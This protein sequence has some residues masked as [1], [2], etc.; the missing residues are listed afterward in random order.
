MKLILKSTQNKAILTDFIEKRSRTVPNNIKKSSFIPYPNVI[1]SDNCH[2]GNLVSS[3]NFSQRG[4]IKNGRLSE[5]KPNLKEISRNKFNN[6]QNFEL[7]NLFS[8]KSDNNHNKENITN[9]I[10]RKGRDLHYPIID[11]KIDLLKEYN[12][13][14]INNFNTKYKLVYKT[15]KPKVK[16]DIINIFSSLKETKSK[17]NKITDK[18][19]QTQNKKYKIITLFNPKSLDEKLWAKKITQH[20]PQEK[21]ISIYTLNFL[22]SK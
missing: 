5:F 11:N 13:Q 7:F 6:Q 18:I 20:Q 14:T 22:Q 21:R 4:R 9:Y 15:K 8:I 2:K 3:F 19:F 12:K 16:E 10:Y 1:D 17:N